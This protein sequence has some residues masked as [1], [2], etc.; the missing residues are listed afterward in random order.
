MST[1]AFKPTDESNVNL[2]TESRKLHV[3]KQM[4][5]FKQSQTGK[6]KKENPDVQEKVASLC[7]VLLCL[8]S[9]GYQVAGMR[10]GLW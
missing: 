1:M 10:M 7:F 6:K 9:V 4:H 2:K 5:K 3:R 8:Q